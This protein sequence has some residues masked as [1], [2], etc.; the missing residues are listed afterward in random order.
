MT[1][2]HLSSG[3]IIILKTAATSSPTTPPGNRRGAS[4]RRS[5]RTVAMTRE[6]PTRP[7]SR[8]ALA[9]EARPSLRRPRQG[10]RQF[11]SR[12]RKTAPAGQADGLPRP[13]GRPRDGAP[14]PD[15]DGFRTGK[16]LNRL[17]FSPLAPS[18]LG[19]PV[20]RLWK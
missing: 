16:T 15:R 2:R 8:E 10:C 11:E 12:G 19:V 9:D 13:R 3:T 5:A 7:A 20:R 17:Y 6:G 18:I 1:S 4:R 14:T